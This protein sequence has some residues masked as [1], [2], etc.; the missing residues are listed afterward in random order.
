MLSLLVREGVTVLNQT[1]SAFYPLIQAD[2]EQP[3]CGIYAHIGCL[4]TAGE[5]FM[6]DIQPFFIADALADF[7]LEKHRLALVYAAERCAVTLTTE[8]LI[9]SLTQAVHPFSGRSEAPSLGKRRK[10]RP[11][12]PGKPSG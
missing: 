10:L 11:P 1:P 4:L 6:K 9:A 2:R 3:I 12:L 8:R 5:A 7:S